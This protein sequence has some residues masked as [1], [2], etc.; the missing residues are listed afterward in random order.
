MI[1]QIIV[2]LLFVAVIGYNM[3]RF[4][5]RKGSKSSGCAKCLP[6]KNIQEAGDR[7]T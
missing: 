6:G 1:Q 5:F 7:R 3:Y 4:F 2:L